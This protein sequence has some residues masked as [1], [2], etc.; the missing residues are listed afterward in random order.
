M[1]RFIIWIPKST[2]RKVSIRFTQNITGCRVLVYN[3]VISNRP[4]YEEIHR[5]LAFHLS[6]RKYSYLQLVGGLRFEL[7]CIGKGQ[8]NIIFAEKGQPFDRTIFRI[9]RVTFQQNAYLFLEW[10]CLHFKQNV[11]V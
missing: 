1:E 8:L 7:L 5:L 10:I 11:L 3:G 6:V 9:N 2:R 4:R